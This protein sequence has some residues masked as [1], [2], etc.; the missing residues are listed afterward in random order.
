VLLVDGD[1]GRQF[2][3][4]AQLRRSGLTVDVANDG[5]SAYQMWQPETYQLVL[6]DFRAAG[7]EVRA[8]CQHVQKRSPAQRIAFYRSTPPLIVSMRNTALPTE[9]EIKLDAE[10]AARE[11][12]SAVANENR[13]LIGLSRAVQDIAM[14]HRRAK[15]APPQ[16]PKPERPG[17]ESHASIA[18]RV[19]GGSK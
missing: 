2:K 14:L 3:R 10:V 4:A 13:R 11:A 7:D 12:V 1:A 19:L 17:P 8:F 6:V 15:P 5:A 16:P 18:E 9:S